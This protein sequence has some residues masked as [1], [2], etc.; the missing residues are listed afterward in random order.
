MKSAVTMVGKMA[1]SK[2]CPS[3]DWMV[4]K[5]AAMKADSMAEKLADQMAALLDDM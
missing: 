1:G 5:K 2:A 3:V 4:D